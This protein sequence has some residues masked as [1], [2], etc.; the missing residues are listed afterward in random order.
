MGATKVEIAKFL[1]E[2][3]ADIGFKMDLTDRTLLHQAAFSG[4]TGGVCYLLEKGANIKAK[5][6]EG[7]TPLHLACENKSAETTRALLELGAKAIVK[8]KN[9]D[10]NTP[11]HVACEYDKAENTKALLELGDKTIVEEKNE[12]G[13]TPLHVACEGG[14][15]ENVKI[16]LD[17]GAKIDVQNTAGETPADIA[18]NDEIKKLVIPKEAPEKGGV[19]KDVHQA[20]RDGDLEALKAAFLAGATV[21]QQALDGSNWT[22]LQIACDKGHLAVVTFLV[23]EKG[24]NIE[25]TDTENRTSLHRACLEGRLETVKYLLE[26]GANTQAQ[27]LGGKT[28]S[29]L[30]SDKGHV[31]VVKLL[32]E[33]PEQRKQKLNDALKAFSQSLEKLADKK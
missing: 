19:K 23:E 32:A 21:E 30:A 13:D 5:D 29:Q 28:P 2:K 11:L 3:G 1:V 31:V 6:F 25:A 33:W 12:D 20:A 8:E 27:A 17:N 7:N 24:A 10:G 22:S 14:S 9:D 18:T 4:F 26:K 15:L 16:L